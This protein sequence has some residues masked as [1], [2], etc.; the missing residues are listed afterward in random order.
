MFGNNAQCFFI[1]RTLEVA[2]RL[3]KDKKHVYNKAD[4][5][6]DLSG[7]GKLQDVSF[8]IMFREH[9]HVVFR[10]LLNYGVFNGIKSIIFL[11][12]VM[13]D[14]DKVLFIRIAKP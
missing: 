4:N 7:D 1:G 8:Y 13:L 10:F 12:W 9:T 2:K 11:F 3:I 5:I 14:S 6:I